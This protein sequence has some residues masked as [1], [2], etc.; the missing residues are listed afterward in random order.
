[1]PQELIRAFDNQNQPILPGGSGPVPNTYFNLLRLQQGEEAKVE[2]PGFETCLVVLSGI[3][4]IKVAGMNFTEVGRRASIWDGP[5]DSVYAGTG[6]VATIRARSE[7]AEI[8]VAGGR[9]GDA[10]GP[11]RVSPEEV[12]PV[13]VGSLETHSHRRIC[14][15]L[16]QNGV[17]RAGNLLI[18]ELFCDHGNWSGYP[19]HKHGIE[20]TGETA[21]EEVYHYRFRPENGFGAQYWY[22][23]EAEPVVHM[24]RSGDTFAF[25][26]GFHPT[27]TSPGHEEY[28]FTILVG[29][30]QRSLVQNFDS[31]Y[32]PLMAMFPGVQDMVDKFK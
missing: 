25:M 23:G 30:E 20:G 26:D 12:D 27:V 2:V 10:F 14:H 17:G 11:F 15:V 22:L 18:S 13:D 5:A 8:A 29:V 32:R 9:C 6:S 31:Q 24:T 21:H 19:P 1:M 16:G 28:I 7:E 3:V 4:D